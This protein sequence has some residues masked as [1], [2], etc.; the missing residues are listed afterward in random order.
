MCL[1]ITVTKK[2]ENQTQLILYQE[3]NIFLQTQ[4]LFLAATNTE[5]AS[6]AAKKNNV[7]PS[8]DRPQ[9][10]QIKARKSYVS[11]IFVNR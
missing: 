11:I 8:I 4:E 2:D 3:K 6:S 7:R 1:L 10:I 9:S 5:S